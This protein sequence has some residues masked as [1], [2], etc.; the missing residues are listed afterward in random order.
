MVHRAGRGRGCE[1]RGDVWV[2]KVQCC[3]AGL[4]QLLGRPASTGSEPPEGLEGLAGQDLGVHFRKEAE[5]GWSDAAEGVRKR[6]DREC[7]KVAD[8]G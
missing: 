7:P 2:Q 6:R 3:R 1:L 5:A 4:G 8:F